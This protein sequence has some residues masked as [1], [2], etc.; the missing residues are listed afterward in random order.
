MALAFLVCSCTERSQDAGRTATVA[1]VGALRI[2]AKDIV[3]RIGVERAYSNDAVPQSAALVGFV[4][5]MLEAAVAE[6][7]GQA[8]TE[9]EI[10]DLGAHA[11]R[12][13]EAPQVLARVKGVFNDDR[14]AYR[15]LY[16]APKIVNRKLRA[17]YTRNA[18]IHD[19]Q[20]SR[21][22]RAYA[23]ARSGES[24]EVAARECQLAYSTF[25]Y[26]KQ[27]PEA[28]ATLRPGFPTG[29]AM[30]EDPMLGILQSLD[31]GQV[32]ENIAEGDRTYRVIRLLEKHDGCYRVEV[33]LAE[34]RPFDEWFREQAEK[35]PVQVYDDDLRREIIAKYPRVWW[36]RR[37]LSQEE[38]GDER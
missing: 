7:C 13:S 19:E 37:W 15:R 4:H 2:A 24:L 6:G 11:D 34:K 8:A 16:L 30:R 22:E 25:E 5:D 35:V 1:S 12:T 36:V 23:L 3:Y 10:D 21:I 31:K 32:Y 18:Q 28:P 17:W 33:I 27:Q 9:E 14:V 26:G 20:R 29:A 38:N